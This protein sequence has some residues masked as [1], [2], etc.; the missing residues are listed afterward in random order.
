[1]Q[2]LQAFL[3][4]YRTQVH[5]PSSM[6]PESKN[7]WKCKVLVVLFSKFTA[8]YFTI[9]PDPKWC[10]AIYSLWLSQLVCIFMFHYR[11]FNRFDCELLPQTHWGCSVMM[12]FCEIWKI[13]NSKAHLTS[14]SQ[15]RWPEYLTEVMI[16]ITML[17]GVS[18]LPMRKGILLYLLFYHLLS[19]LNNMSWTPF[20]SV[21]VRQQPY[22]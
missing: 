9:Q 15:N 4:P 20:I 5:R 16:I 17:Y 2:C 10:D 14:R 11:N 13:L 7:L 1:M 12:H 3:M 6:I 19:A 21:N 22:L 8:I 18:I